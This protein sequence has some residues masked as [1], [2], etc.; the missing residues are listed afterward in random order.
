[1]ASSR[2]ASSSEAASKR[3]RS[4]RRA[5][6]KPELAFRSAL[7]RLG[8]RFRKDFPIRLC[9][10]RSVR[11]DVV[12]P[13]ARLAIFIDGCFWH[14]CPEHGTLPKANRRYWSAKLVENQERDRAT[15]LALREAGWTV[16]R[17][18][19]H[20]DPRAAAME[21]ARRVEAKPSPRRYAPGLAKER[22]EY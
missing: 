15:D 1:M 2:I 3:M 8:L 16:L 9:E 7:H 5:E 22:P 11:P 17:F 6:T 21:V 4:N 10:R 12:F 19:A 14:A 20:E 13:R 18:W